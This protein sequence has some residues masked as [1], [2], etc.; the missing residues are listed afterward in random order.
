M[1]KAAITKL[2][3]VEKPKN[4]DPAIYLKNIFSMY[5]GKMQNIRLKCDADMMKVIIDRFGVNTQTI[6]C[7]D[8][9]FITDVNV[10]ISPT[11]WGWLFGF[12]GKIRVTAPQKLIQEYTQTLNAEIKR[13]TT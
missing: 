8:G 5:D 6:S 13:Y 12:H 11:F 7:E 4:F 2:N 3:A 9:S 1:D 10:S